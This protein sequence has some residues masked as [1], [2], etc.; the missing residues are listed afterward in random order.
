MRYTSAGSGC[1]RGQKWS[2]R[3]PTGERTIRSFVTCAARRRNRRTA[4]RYP[5]T[6]EHRRPATAAGIGGN[7]DDDRLPFHGPAG[8][9]PRWPM[10][11]SPNRSPVLLAA[12]QPPPVL[13]R[14]W[15]TEPW[16]VP[17]AL[18]L[19]CIARDRST[20]SENPGRFHHRSH[21][22]RL[23]VRWSARATGQD[24]PP[25]LR[26]RCAYSVYARAAAA[27][28]PA[29]PA[30]AQPRRFRAWQGSARQAAR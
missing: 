29:E 21:A 14:R 22:I 30:A 16:R 10:L 23:S 24:V 3:G 15:R 25:S 1:C 20:H 2:Q 11:A 18:P 4:R 5:G 19:L 7:D 26:F 12:A 8:P 28:P 17:P 27:S 9:A 13:R 6:P